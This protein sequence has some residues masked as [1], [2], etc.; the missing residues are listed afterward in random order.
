MR[1]DDAG[2]GSHQIARVQNQEI[3]DGDFAAGDVALDAVPNDACS[4]RK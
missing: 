2:V 4:G 3:S 1:F